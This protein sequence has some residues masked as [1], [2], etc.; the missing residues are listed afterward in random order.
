MLN[1]HN[2]KINEADE[3]HVEG[4]LLGCA[5]WDEESEKW[6]AELS[7]NGI[8]RVAAAEIRKELLGKALIF[9]AKVSDSLLNP[10]CKQQYFCCQDCFDTMYR[11]ELRKPPYAKQ[12]ILDAA[13]VFD[14]LE[15]G[16]VRPLQRTMSGAQPVSSASL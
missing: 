11:C 16:F 2:A 6:Q 15:G 9:C 10:I 1:Q 8:T 13:N 14:W 3:I 4:K 7:K 5:A 12:Y